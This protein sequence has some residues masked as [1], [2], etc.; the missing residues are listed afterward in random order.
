MKWR[1]TELTPAMRILPTNRAE[2][3][4]RLVLQRR[5]RRG[6]ARHRHAERAARHVVQPDLVAELHAV[7][8]TA[9]FA[10]Y[11]DLQLRPLRPAFLHTHLHQ[12]A[13]AVLV[14]RRERVG[15]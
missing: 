6:Q 3:L 8:V 7:R 14:D 2:S 12:P 15:V 9:V 5:L 4:L 11:A 1:T 13:D 10:A